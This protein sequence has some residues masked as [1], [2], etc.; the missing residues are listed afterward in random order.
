MK[1]LCDTRLMLCCDESGIELFDDTS[2]NQ[3]IAVC[4][5]FR[6]DVTHVAGNAL[7]FSVYLERLSS[8]SNDG[9]LT[10]Y[11]LRPRRCSRSCGSL[12]GLH[13]QRTKS[14]V[15]SLL[16]TERL[17]LGL[18]NDWQTAA[19]EFLAHPD[20]LLPHVDGHIPR[21]SASIDR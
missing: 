6:F 19:D 2:D 12:V 9:F 8:I 11:S 10:T 15:N 1:N 18:T 4:F 20:V 14:N 16:L 21:T 5:E 17:N 3:C 13:A 7:S